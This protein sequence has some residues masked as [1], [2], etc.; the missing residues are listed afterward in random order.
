MDSSFD[1]RGDYDASGSDLEEEE[2]GAAGG[3]ERLAQTESVFAHFVSG[4]GALSELWGVFHF[5]VLGLF[6]AVH[7]CFWCLFKTRTVIK[8]ILCEQL[9]GT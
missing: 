5:L 4:N 9:H 3:A 6:E 2:G 7:L 1:Q 8:W